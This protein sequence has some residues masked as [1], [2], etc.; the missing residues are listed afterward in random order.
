MELFAE[1]THSF[2]TI[3]GGMKKSNRGFWWD[4]YVPYFYDLAKNDHT[5]SFCYYIAQLSTPDDYNNWYLKNVEK[6]EVF[7]E[8]YIKN[9]RKG[10]N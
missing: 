4:F 10:K 2:F 9:D 3:L 5:A 8:W 1:N 7:S 6:L